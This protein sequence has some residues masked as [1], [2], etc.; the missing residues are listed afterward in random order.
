[1]RRFDAARFSIRPKKLPA[2]RIYRLFPIKKAA[3]WAAFL[4]TALAER[5]YAYFSSIA[6]FGQPF[7]E[8]G[9]ND[10]AA[11]LDF[12]GQPI[13]LVNF[14]LGARHDFLRE[15][16]RNHAYAVSVATMMSPGRTATPP[17]EIT[18]LISPF[19]FLVLEPHVTDLAKNRESDFLVFIDITKRAVHDNALEPEQFCRQ[20][21]VVSPERVIPAPPAVDDND[22]SGLGDRQGL[23]SPAGCAH[24]QLQRNRGPTIFFVVTIG[25]M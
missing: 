14:L 9:R 12:F 17:Q 11:V 5:L 21:S 6:D 15:F 2:A 7:L 22:V 18:T 16:R 1:M 13:H 25:L 20:A 3:L 4:M 24:H 8:I 10:S 23:L 19:E